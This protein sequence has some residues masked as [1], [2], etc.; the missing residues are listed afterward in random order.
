MNRNNRYCC[1]FI[2]CEIN[3]ECNYFEIDLH[4]KDLKKIIFDIN[5]ELKTKFNYS[6]AKIDEKYGIIIF[7]NN[8]LKNEYINQLSGKNKKG[9]CLLISHVAN[10]NK[11]IK[12]Y[13][14]YNKN[15]HLINHNSNLCKK[16]LSLCIEFIISK[17]I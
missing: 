17:D 15:S 13:S 5:S 6:K 3:K 11:F 7:E 8:L 14:S 4:V 9:N 1:L 10:F 12:N 16:M 2:P